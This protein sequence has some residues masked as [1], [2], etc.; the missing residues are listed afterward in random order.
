MAKK[1][2]QP[3]RITN[4]PKSKEEPITNELYMPFEQALQLLISPDK[5]ENDKK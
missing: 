4:K 2:T 3:K 1:K 5:K